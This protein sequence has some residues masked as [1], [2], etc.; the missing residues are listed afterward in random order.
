MLV[1]IFTTRDYE[2]L[3]QQVNAFL[4]TQKNIINIKLATSDTEDGNTVFTVLIM[5]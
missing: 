2:E 5:Y 1:K 3:E 4:E